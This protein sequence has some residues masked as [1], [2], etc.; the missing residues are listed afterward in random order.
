[1]E[2]VETYYR[3]VLKHTG[4][5]YFTKHLKGVITIDQYVARISESTGGIKYR[6][7]D[8]IIG[9]MVP[10]VLKPNPINRESK[11][12]L[13]AL[14]KSYMKGQKM[15]RLQH[16]VDVIERRDFAEKNKQEMRESHSKAV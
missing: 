10:E 1:M 9:V 4:K 8:D 6:V 2:L 16:S 3:Y 14:N 15:K 7:L 13:S 11:N 5:D 12:A